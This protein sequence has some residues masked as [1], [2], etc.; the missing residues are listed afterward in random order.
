MDY[1]I[2]AASAFAFSCGASVI[3]SDAASAWYGATVRARPLPWVGAGSEKRQGKNKER[4]RGGSRRIKTA[5]ERQCLAGLASCR[6]AL[7]MPIETPTDGRGGVQQTATAGVV[8]CVCVLFCVCVCVCVVMCWS[9]ARALSSRCGRSRRYRSCAAL[10]EDG[11]KEM[12]SPVYATCI[13]S[14]WFC[15]WWLSWSWRSAANSTS[16]GSAGGSALKR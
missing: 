6:H 5:K 1:D 12:F 4:Y 2:F 14:L 11:T 15:S 10:A 16:S 9:P 13:S 3:P 8:T 7:S